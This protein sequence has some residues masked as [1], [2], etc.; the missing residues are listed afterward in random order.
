MKE[1]VFL[2]AGFL[3]LIIVAFDF[4]YT[5]LSGSGAS[6]MTKF[7]SRKIHLLVLWAGRAF[8]RKVFGLSGMLV[9]LSVLALWVLL[10]WLGLFLVFS[11]NPEAITNSKGIPADT[12]ERLYFTGYVIS[13]LGIGDW[14]PNTPFFEIITSLFSFFGFVFFTTSMTYLLS[15][16]TGIVNK[17]S[18]ALAV[19]NLGSSPDEVV[20]G[21]LDMDTSFAYQQLSSLQQ[22]VDTHATY[23]QAYPVMHY[24][25]NPM[26]ESSL[27]TSLAVL[28][29]ALS[30]LLS[31]RHPSSL[32]K[33]ILPLRN[34]LSH[35]FKRIE[36][37][38]GEKAGGAPDINWHSLHLPQEM[39]QAGFEE[40]STLKGRRKVLGDLLNNEGLSWRDVYL[41]SAITGEKH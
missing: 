3:L 29:E 7:V 19:R 22:L 15:V 31:S 11:F 40:I 16:S 30:M 21:L 10:V 41:E 33:E 5:T 24:Y 36:G 18:I 23:Y 14:K 27:S 38:Y 17:R 6:F 32:K 13:T 37:K 20:R 1:I 28:D 2:I 26:K 9:N 25:N 8:G 39:L 34:S 12:V 4:F 35:F